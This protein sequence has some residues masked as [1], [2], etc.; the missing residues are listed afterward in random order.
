MANRDHKVLYD[1]G[2]TLLRTTRSSGG[3]IVNLWQKPGYGVVSQSKAL[4]IERRAKRE[5]K[6]RAVNHSGNLLAGIDVLNAVALI[7]E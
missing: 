3:L 5:M 4:Q 1:T 7:D 6:R 2:W